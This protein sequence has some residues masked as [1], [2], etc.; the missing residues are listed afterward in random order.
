PVDDLQH[1]VEAGSGDDR[2]GATSGRDDVQVCDTVDV[3]VGG[4]Q[5]GA[6]GELD[7]GRHALCDDGREP[8]GGRPDPDAEAAV[9]RLDRPQILGA[10]AVD[11][12]EGVA[13]AGRHLGTDRRRRLVVVGDRVAVEHQAG[14]AF[15]QEQQV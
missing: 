6:G 14:P 5:T 12:A 4:G 13:E 3:A 1:R 7:T 10:V 15:V 9:C 2:V 11:V 8:A